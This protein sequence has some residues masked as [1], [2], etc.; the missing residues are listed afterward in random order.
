MGDVVEVNDNVFI[1]AGANLEVEKLSSNKKYWTHV[2]DMRKV[3]PSAFY[4]QQFT[5]VGINNEIY[6]FGGIGTNSISC[7]QKS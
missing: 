6:T 3:L 7:Q 5:S 4:Y 1:F 2:G